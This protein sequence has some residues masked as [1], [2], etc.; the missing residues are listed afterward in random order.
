MRFHAT[1][2]HTPESCPGPRGGT[3]V[4]DW[5]G[6]AKE[7]GVELISAAAPVGAMFP[8][9]VDMTQRVLDLVK[10]SYRTDVGLSDP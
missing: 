9:E 3:P 10:V 6:K 8:G 1:L 2:T 4:P 7:M 5:P